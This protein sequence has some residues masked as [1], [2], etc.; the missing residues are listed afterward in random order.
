[1]STDNRSRTVVDTVLTCGQSNIIHHAWLLQFVIRYYCTVQVLVAGSGRSVSV[2]FSGGPS[3]NTYC[4]RVVYVTCMSLRI[5]CAAPAR[6][7]IQK[8]DQRRDGGGD[9]ISCW[10]LSLSWLRSLLSASQGSIDRAS[11]W[12]PI[13]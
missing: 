3:P 2:V 6:P 10:R 13:L 1:M 7:E 5:R 12:M 8:N 11:S 9:K 4:T